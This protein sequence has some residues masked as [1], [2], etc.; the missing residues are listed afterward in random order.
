MKAIRIHRYGA[1]DVLVLHEIPRPR[2][3]PN[4]LLVKVRA[5]GV[6][7]LDWKIRAGMVGGYLDYSL[8]FTLGW[9]FSDILEDV[10]P[11]PTDFKAGD[12]VFG[13]KELR[14]GGACADFVLVN[15]S[16]VTSK[17]SGLS[18]EQ[19]A[20]VPLTAL[21]AWQALFEAGS[22][23]GGHSALIHAGA[24]GVGVFAIRMGKWKGARVIAT[25]PG[26]NLDFLRDL[27]S[28]EVIDYTTYQFEDCCRDVDLVLDSVGGDTIDRS[29]QT[30]RPGG[31][32]ISTTTDLS[33][34]VS[35][36]S[37]SG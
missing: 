18:Y 10:G 34:Q 35:G 23:E 29:W 24:G 21:T 11:G 14:S 15:P 5:A 2:P 9:D 4:E 6:N 7:P 32:M 3:G 30:L 31:A 17:P 13:L 27:G 33:S 19:A 12:S 8:P 28:D 1:P 26:H 37:S 22:L 20:V 36:A 16:E 25:S